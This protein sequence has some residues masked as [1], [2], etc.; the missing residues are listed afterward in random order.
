MALKALQVNAMN[1]DIEP[2]K[3]QI[4]QL[5]NAVKDVSF[6]LANAIEAASAATT[7]SAESLARATRRLVW[8]T[9]ALVF[10]TAM[11][12]WIDCRVLVNR[13]FASFATRTPQLVPEWPVGARGLTLG[14]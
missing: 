6:V 3:T 8:S 9:A 14:W 10:A 2:S 12:A 13:A 1:E 7:S 11:Q 4:N 5:S